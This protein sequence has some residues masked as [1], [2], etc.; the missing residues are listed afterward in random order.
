[1]TIHLDPEQERLIGLAI[2]AGLIRDVDDVIKAG[3]DSLRSRLESPSVSTAKAD[4]SSWEQQLHRWV[5]SHSTS[6]PLLTDEAISRDS[7]YPTRD[8]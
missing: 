2:Q 4:A 6:S 7:I 3:L 1:V 8:V 5:S